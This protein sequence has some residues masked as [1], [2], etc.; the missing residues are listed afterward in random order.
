MG[1]VHR[2]T[3]KENNKALEIYNIGGLFCVWFF[4]ESLYEWLSGS[5]MLKEYIYRE[6]VEMVGYRVGGMLSQNM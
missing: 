6:F 5:T 2:N 4:Y 3:Y 1:V